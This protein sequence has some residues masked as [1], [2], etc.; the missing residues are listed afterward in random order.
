MKINKNQIIKIGF[1]VA[2]I[3]FISFTSAFS[4]SRP[5]MKD[6][7]LNLHPGEIK[8]LEFVLQNSAGP[9]TIKVR[10]RI[11]Q[12]IE[13]ANISDESDI[14]T[15]VPGDKVPVHIKIEIPKEVQIGDSYHMKL[16]FS[17]VTE[18]EAGIFG[19]GTEIEQNF[20]VIIGEKPKPPKK[21]FGELIKTN[22]YIAYIT[23]AII[24]I[25]SIWFA[26]KRRKQKQQITI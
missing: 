19:F 8:D 4:V 7:Q 26:I 24:I 14:Y 20:E 15:V 25:I 16:G 1:I 10:V 11:K 3:F 9:G 18:E 23:I 17:T 21:S 2:I 22:Q 13:I 6:K 5:Y 12:G